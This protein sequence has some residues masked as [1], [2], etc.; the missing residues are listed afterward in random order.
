MATAANFGLMPA[1]AIRPGGMGAPRPTT[2]LIYIYVVT[3]PMF[4]GYDNQYDLAKN[5]IMYTLLFSIQEREQNGYRLG[6][7]LRESGKIWVPHMGL[8]QCLWCFHICYLA[9]T[10]KLFRSI[11]C[12][13]LE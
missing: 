13:L 2:R 10:K 4:V 1:G 3:Q 5:I 7:F 9:I 8:V 12:F 6:T 11:R